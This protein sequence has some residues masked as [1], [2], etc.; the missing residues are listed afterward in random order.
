MR[1]LNFSKR[2]EMCNY[3]LLSCRYLNVLKEK[4]MHFVSTIHSIG[5]E[6]N[7]I[8]LAETMNVCSFYLVC[9]GNVP[10]RRSSL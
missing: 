1:Q 10:L 4:D 6:C 9:A 2:Y 5:V 3:T 7:V 8:E